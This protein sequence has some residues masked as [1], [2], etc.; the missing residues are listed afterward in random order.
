M[1]L[2]VFL[3]ILFLCHSGLQAQDKV[4]DSLMQKVPETSGDLEKAKLFN[5]I[6]NQYKY[7][8]PTKMLEFGNKAFK[9]AE[10]KQLKYEMGTAYLSIGTAHIILG[11]Y[12]KAMDN[13]HE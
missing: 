8:D 4:L 13:C 5:A 10:A 7:S 2:P 9:L 6:S 12:Q 1:R 11:A 3:F